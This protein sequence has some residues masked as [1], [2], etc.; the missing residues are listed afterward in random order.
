[1]SFASAFGAKLSAVGAFTKQA[2]NVVV[3][4]AA[5]VAQQAAS[6]A[7]TAAVQAKDQ[8]LIAAENMKPQLEQAAKAG[9]DAMQNAPKLA[10]EFAVFKLNILIKYYHLN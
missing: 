1:M 5:P 9:M 6:A 2:T 7:S 10:G 3:E 8:A 4:N